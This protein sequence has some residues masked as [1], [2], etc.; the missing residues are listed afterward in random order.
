MVRSMMKHF[1]VPKRFW[2]E[3]LS[4]ALYI[5]NRVT[6]RAL[7]SDRTPQH[8]RHCQASSLKHLRVFGC[9]CWYTVPTVRVKKLDPRGR[10]SI[11]VGYAET[12]KAYRVLHAETRKMDVSRYFAFDE[13]VAGHFE[14]ESNKSDTDVVDIGDI[15]KIETPIGGDSESI[16][17]TE[18][19]PA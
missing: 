12:S 7:P 19:P 17:P 16:A 2:A 11:F 5:R 1:G 18:K 6:S 3:A 15:I 9:K 4:T 8:I 14:G 10:P 13:G